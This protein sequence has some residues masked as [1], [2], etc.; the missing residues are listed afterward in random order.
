MGYIF[1][2]GDMVRTDDGTLFQVIS[3]EPDN[4]VVI[5][6]ITGNTFTCHKSELRLD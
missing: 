1:E 4:M 6:S 2:L 5:R 3:F